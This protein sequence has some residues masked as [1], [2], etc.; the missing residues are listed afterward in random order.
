MQELALDFLLLRRLGRIGRATMTILCRCTLQFDHG[1]MICYDT[2]KA[3][4]APQGR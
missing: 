3:D 4:S 1:V 2:L